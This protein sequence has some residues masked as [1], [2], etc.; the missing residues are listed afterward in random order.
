[1]KIHSLGPVRT[2]SDYKALVSVSGRFSKLYEVTQGTT[3][4][5]AGKVV[6]GGRASD[7]G[8]LFTQ[9]LHQ[10]RPSRK[11]LGRAQEIS[12]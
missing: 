3:A 11:A 1:M 8:Q 10:L 9:L 7:V 12:L 2:S 5:Y 4:V 6:G